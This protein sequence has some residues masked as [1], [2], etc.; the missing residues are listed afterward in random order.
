MGSTAVVDWCRFIG[1]LA[2]TGVTLLML[3]ADLAHMWVVPF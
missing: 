1:L 2:L 3:G